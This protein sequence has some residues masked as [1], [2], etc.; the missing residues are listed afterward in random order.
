LGALLKDYEEIGIST[1]GGGEEEEDESI[2]IKIN[3]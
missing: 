1:S 3:K 2:P